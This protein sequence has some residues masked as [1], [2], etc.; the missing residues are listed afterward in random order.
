MNIAIR[1]VLAILLVIAHCFRAFSCLILA[2][3]LF[4]VAFLTSVTVQN[5]LEHSISVTP[6]GAVGVDGTRY[7]L[8]VCH[9]FIIS[10]PSAVRGGY[11]LRPNESVTITYDM[12]DINFSEIVVDDITGTIGQ[13]IVNANPVA[14]QYRAPKENHFLVKRDALVAVPMVVLSAAKDAQKP[15]Y[16]A[17]IL[18]SVLVLPWIAVAL[19]QWLKEKHKTIGRKT[20]QVEEPR[21]VPEL[22]ITRI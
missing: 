21:S 7:P 1:V 12:D 11:V 22:P 14:D 9:N 6:V 2:G 20:S 5:G 17:S 4:E 3:M 8:P 18:L 19:L 10:V 13:L 15:T 16:G